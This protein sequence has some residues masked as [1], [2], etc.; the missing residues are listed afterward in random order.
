MSTSYHAGDIEVLEGLDPVRRRPGMYTD[1][2]SPEHLAWEVI[3]N[4]VDEALAGHARSIEVTLHAD[5]SLAVRDDGRGMPVDLHPVLGRPGVEIIL[6]TLHAGSKF[7]DRIYRYA[8]GLH[9]VGVSVVNALSRRLE[10]VVWRDGGEYRAAFA[11]GETVEPLRRVGDARGSV[12]GTLVR[13]WP[14]PRYFATAGFSYDRLAR[15]LRAKAVLLPGLEV[16]LTAE[17]PPRSD[18]WRYEEGLGPYLAEALGETVFRPSPPLVFTVPGERMSLE[19]ALAWVDPDEAEGARPAESYVNLVPTPLGGTHVAGL[20]TGV[21]EAVREFCTVRGLV[22]RGLKLG[23]EDIVGSLAYVLSIRLREAE[24]AGQTKERLTAREAQGATA[25]ALKDAVSLWLHRHPQAGEEI[26]AGLVRLAQARQQAAQT[27]TRKKFSAALALPGKLADCT[28]R[29]LESSE[30]FLVEGDSAGGSA[31]QARDRTVQAVLALRGK[32]LNT[33]ESRSEEIL[34]SN[35]VRDITHAL[36][37]APGST[38]TR[39]LRYGKVC[40]L[41]D[42]DSDGAHIA[43]LLLALFLRHFRILVA[44]GRVHVAQPPLYRIDF[45]ETV[46][47]ARDDAERDRLLETLSGKASGRRPTITRFKGL[48]E[49]NP[50]Q[51]RLTTMDPASRRLV[52]LVLAD[53]EAARS[54]EDVFHM[55]LTRRRAGDRKLW[56]ERR[57]AEARLE[58]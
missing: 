4:S 31:R 30:L 27:V 3:D 5:G 9:G 14:E 18:R 40:I 51:L 56:L 22:P 47:Y 15:L 29:D 53:A 8:G 35:E 20:R 24:F 37:I 11:Q 33:W 45:G 43:T 34:A 39:G 13:F 50:E 23:I 2:A 32:I 38:D 58:V 44:E 49:M 19:C 48:G 36:G 7:S 57:G 52:R 42:A 55:M 16:R 12:H 21:G 25:G 54:A 26:V 1:T 28:S 41:A 17:D 6:T 10:V 46:A